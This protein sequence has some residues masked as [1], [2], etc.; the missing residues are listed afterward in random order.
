M[1][2]TLQEP[3]STIAPIPDP[4]RDPRVKAVFDDI[5]AT[6]KTDF[7]NNLWRAWRSTRPCWKRPGP[8]SSR[9]WPRPAPSTR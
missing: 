9:S 8:R 7:I 4:E 3:M 5:R 2:P 1:S 6:R